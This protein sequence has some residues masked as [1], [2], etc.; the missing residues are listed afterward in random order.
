MKWIKKF[1]S[2]VEEVKNDEPV[3]VVEMDEMHTYV[4]EKKTINGYGLLLIEKGGNTLIS[5][6]GQEGQKQGSSYGKK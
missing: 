3:E 5:L 4:R 2:Q 1:G 6:L